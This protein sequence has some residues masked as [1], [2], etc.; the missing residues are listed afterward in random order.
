MQALQ[1]TAS[2]HPQDSEF[3]EFTLLEIVQAICDVTEDDSEVV[4]TVRHMLHSG[5]LRLC[6]NFRNAPP[7]AFD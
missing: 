3:G 5:R 7:E 4:A 1:R 2:L 6:G